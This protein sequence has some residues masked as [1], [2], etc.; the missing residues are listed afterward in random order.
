[1]TFFVALLGCLI[2]GIGLTVLISPAWMRPAIQAVVN[3]RWLPVLS[4]ARIAFGIVLVL[5]APATRLPIFVWALGLLMIVAGVSLPFMG[6]K[7][8]Q[9]MA[10]WWLSRPDRMLRTWSLLAILLGALLVWAAT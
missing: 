8:I 9:A 2:L 7:R 6:M 4:A 1:M 10:D 5:A 3:R